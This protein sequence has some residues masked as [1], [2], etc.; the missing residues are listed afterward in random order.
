VPAQ[1]RPYPYPAETYLIFIPLI[2]ELNVSVVILPNLRNDRSFPS[3]N[4]RMVLGIDRHGQ[5]EAPQCLQEMSH[6]Y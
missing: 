6:R 1:T 3:D 4:L 2:R 5:L